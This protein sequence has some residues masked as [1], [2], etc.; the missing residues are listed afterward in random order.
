MAAALTCLGAAVS[1]YHPAGLAL[2]SQGIRRSGRALGIHGI[3]GSIGLA[4]GWF[5][6]QMAILGSWRAAYGITSAIALVMAVLVAL[7]CPVIPRGT[8]STVNS[9]N[10]QRQAPSAESAQSASRGLMILLYAAM[11]LS[12][13]NY[14]TL[15]T[16]LPT[17]LTANSPGNYSLGAGDWIVLLVFVAGGISQYATGRIADVRQPMRLYRFLIAASVPCALLLALSGGVGHVA[18]IFAVLLAL[19]HFGTQPIENLLIARH[20]PQRLRGT[21]YGIKFVLTFGLGALAVPLVGRLWEVTGTLA[22]SFV[23][24]AAVALLVTVLV[25]RLVAIAGSQHAMES[26]ARPLAHHPNQP[27]RRAPSTLPSSH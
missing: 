16:A 4:G 2:I 23:T 12:G 22:Y 6:M 14:R 10:Q 24:F 5:G 1:L 7:L 3:A 25:V 9:A 27:G 13:F 17:Y 11:M 26:H 18:L 21:S 19:V 15:M 20:T 8:V